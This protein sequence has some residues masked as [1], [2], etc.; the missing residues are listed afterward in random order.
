MPPL[1]VVVVAYHAPKALREALL[2][3]VVVDNS[4]DDDV[5]AVANDLGATFL[6][7]GGNLGFGRGV[8]LALEQAVPR[9]MTCCC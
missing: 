2:P 7:A 4:D 8:N 3:L 6:P 9:A 1:T 5:R